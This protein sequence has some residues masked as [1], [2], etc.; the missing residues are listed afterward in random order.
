MTDTDAETDARTRVR[1]RCIA[2]RVGVGLYGLPVEQVQEVIAM[3]PVTRVFHAPAALAGVTNLRGEVLPVLELGILLGAE[4]ET[5][6]ADARIVVVREPTGQERRA[7]LRVDEALGAARRAGRA[8]P[9]PQTAGERA[10][11]AI[12]GVITEAPPCALLDVPS[13]LDSSLL[14]GLAGRGGDDA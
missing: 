1:A 4:A 7:G 10:R 6:T 12:R 5:P 13:L 9:A 8:A 2:V 14:V 3:R 11:A